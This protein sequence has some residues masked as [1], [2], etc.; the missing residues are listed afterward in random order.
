VP[1]PGDFVAPGPNSSPDPGVLSAGDGTGARGR[2]KS[3][4]EPL[5]GRP[6][7]RV[8]ESILAVAVAGTRP[9]PRPPSAPSA[10][11]TFFRIFN[12]TTIALAFWLCFALVVTSEAALLPVWHFGEWLE[13]VASLVRQYLFCAVLVLAAVAAGEALLPDRPGHPHRRAGRTALIVLGS[14]GGFGLSWAFSD[15]TSMSL[16]VLVTWILVSAILWTMLGLFAAGVAGAWLR[17]TDLRR[18][19]FENDTADAALA[20]RASEA[21]LAALQAQIEPHFLFNTL[22][23]VRRLYEV[24]AALGHR[25]L[26]SLLDYLRAALPAMRRSEAT[27]ADELELVRAYLTVLRHRMGDRLRFDVRFEPSIGGFAIP[28]LIVPTL[29]ENAV[30]HGLAPLPEGGTIRIEAA[31]RDGAIVIAIRDD[32]AG[33]KADSGSGVGLSNTRARL[34]AQYG[35]AAWLELRRNEP[36][37]VIAEIHLPATEMPA[38]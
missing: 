4:S 21:R 20:A 34:A 9:P 32:G 31:P 33:F 16:L 15:H 17:D 2:G 26:G 22:A 36:R 7:R 10:R 13:K 12:W 8:S 1:D 11:A 3:D 14:V 25:M 6:M 37:G 35:A 23:N 5:P 27:L 18:R 29:V 30:R 28:P 38:A 19:M 24:D